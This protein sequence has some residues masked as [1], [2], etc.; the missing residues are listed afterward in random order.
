LTS[1]LRTK[2]ELTIRL[3]LWH[4]ILDA[5]KFA[6]SKQIYHGDLHD[7]NIIINREKAKLID[8]GT[9]IFAGKKYK[10]PLERESKKIIEIVKR[11]FP[12]LDMLSINDLIMSNFKPEIILQIADAAVE[13]NLGLLELSRAVRA[14][15]SRLIK[16]KLL[17]IGT[18]IENN[19]F[20]MPEYIIKLLID[21]NI[22]DIYIGYFL[23]ILL[24]FTTA[25]IEGRGLCT[26][27]HDPD[28]PN[29]KKLIFINDNLQKL[30]T[31][32][33]PLYV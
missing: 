21:S 13:I 10:N 16:V 4:D 15:D 6:H 5:L 32:L 11:I 2:R 3:N 17:E 1:F 22:D 18:D 8:F 29:E 27:K 26:V 14:N 23:D 31:K 33:L 25:N 30:R 28:T 19:P 20:F 9:S 12:E 24:T 7:G